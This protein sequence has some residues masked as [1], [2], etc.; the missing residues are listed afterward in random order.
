MKFV[1]VAVSAVKTPKGVTLYY[2]AVDAHG[3]TW[4]WDTGQ[5]T[6]EW[7]LLPPHPERKGDAD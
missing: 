7:Q 6:T 2:A 3:R 5:S 1:S 4:W